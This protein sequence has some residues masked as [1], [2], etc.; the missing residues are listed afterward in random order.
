MNKDINTV[1]KSS[2]DIMRLLSEADI[3]TL[4]LVLQGMFA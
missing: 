1:I 3:A 2:D 4:T